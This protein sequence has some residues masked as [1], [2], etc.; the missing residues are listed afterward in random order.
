MLNLMKAVEPT[1]GDD[2]R[3]DDALLDSYSNTVTAVA[4]AVSPSVVCIDVAGIE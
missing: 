3:H 4:A 1:T 2:K